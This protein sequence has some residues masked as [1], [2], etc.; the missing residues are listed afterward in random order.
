MTSLFENR[1]ITWKGAITLALLVLAINAFPAVVQAGPEE[2]ES[3]IRRL[4]KDGFNRG[5]TSIVDEIFDSTY[6]AHV[7]GQYVSGSDLV[8]QAILYC[9]DNGYHY[10]IEEIHGWDDRVVVCCTRIPGHGDPDAARVYEMM[11]CT[12]NEG[13]LVESW[14]VTSGEAGH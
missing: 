12:F 9:H 1:L 2:N 8:K 5:D 13:K 10:E 3:E 6:E 7:N 4:L 11:I 14:K